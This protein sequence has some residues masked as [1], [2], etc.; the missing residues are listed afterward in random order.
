MQARRTPEQIERDNALAAVQVPTCLIAP[1]GAKPYVRRAYSSAEELYREIVVSGDEGIE[2]RK[3]GSGV[4]K[5]RRAAAVKLLRKEG[6][7]DESTEQRDQAARKL[8]VFRAASNSSAP[9]E[10]VSASQ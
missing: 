10:T 6:V 7:L 9:Q 4:G 2:L 8:I 3:L 5:E 1:A